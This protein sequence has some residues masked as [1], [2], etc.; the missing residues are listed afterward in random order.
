MNATE[1]IGK[2]GPYE[3]LVDYIEQRN[4]ID[5][6]IARLSNSS[7]TSEQI[8]VV[9]KY[10]GELIQDEA[11]FI[12]FVSKYEGVDHRILKLKYIDGL[13]LDEIPEKLNVSRTW[14]AV[15]HADV[16]KLFK[17]LEGIEEQFQ[18]FREGTRRRKELSA[19]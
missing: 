7:L 1:R 2:L 5:Y 12:E 18:L 17:G 8:P 4:K 6:W 11:E 13:T 15:K 19:K 14:V 10:I 9:Q 3:W 16:M